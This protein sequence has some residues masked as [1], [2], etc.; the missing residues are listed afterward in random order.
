MTLNFIDS[1]DAISS[2]LIY[3]I[4]FVVGVVFTRLVFSIPKIVRE[5][6]AQTLLTAKI[7]EK[8]GVQKSEIDEILHNAHA[9]WLK[10]N[11][12]ILDSKEEIAQNNAS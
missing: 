1:S 12:T 2:T 8:Q 4:A 9:P 7:A 10:R 11:T 3:V 5:L 6:K